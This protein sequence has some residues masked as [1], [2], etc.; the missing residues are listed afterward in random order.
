MDWNTEFH[1]C[2]PLQHHRQRHRFTLAQLAQKRPRT[3][4][5]WR[6]AA[7]LVILQ[8]PDVCNLPCWKAGRA[9]RI[10][11]YDPTEQNSASNTR[12]MSRD[13][14]VVFVQEWCSDSLLFL[15]LQYHFLSNDM[16]FRRKTVEAWSLSRPHQWLW[17]VQMMVR[18]EQEGWYCRVSVGTSPHKPVTSIRDECSRRPCWVCSL[19]DVWLYVTN[20]VKQ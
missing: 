1:I 18:H 16:S 11:L 20:K 17:W 19:T 2:L 3:W 5:V 14:A 10:R 7:D 13:C 9:G 8:P 15:F 12:G 6:F 4:R